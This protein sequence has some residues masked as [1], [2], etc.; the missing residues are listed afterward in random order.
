VID[1]QRAH[2]LSIAVMI[3][4]FVTGNALPLLFLLLA[5]GSLG[6]ELI[7]AMLGLVSV[8]AG[9]LRWWMTTYAVTA[10]TVEHRTGVFQRRNRSIRLD[11]IQQVTAVQALIPRAVGLA[12]VRVSEASADGDV[13]ISYLRLDAAE[14]LT[15]RLRSMVA[16][17]AQS[18]DP[19]ESPASSLPPPPSPPAVRLHDQ[20]FDLLLR[21][22]LAVV[23]PLVLVTTVALGVGV[24][25]TGL[26]PGPGAAGLVA[27]FG[28]ATIVGLGVLGVAPV[29]VRLGG[30]RLDRRGRTLR[31]AAGLMARRE[32]EVRTDRIQTLTV[33]SGPVARRWG[34][35]EVRFSAATGSAPAGESLGHLGPAV[36]ADRVAALVQGSVDLDPALGVE[37]EPVSP[38]TVRRALV[39]SGL[40]FVVPGSLVLALL[41]SVHPL[42]AAV[43]G[44]GWWAVAVWYARA[45]FAR[46][47][48]TVD[49]RRLVVR[50]GVLQHHL[51][52]LAVGNVQSVSVV[53]SFFQRRLVLADL[54]VAT[55]GVGSD[56]YVRIPDL[57]AA[58]AEELARRL[59]DAAAAT[60]WELRG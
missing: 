40:L 37:L 24:V 60:R 3:V 32:T 15:T 9:V 22:Q 7:G 52:Q 21:Y 46:L 1:W 56:H 33:G 45:R 53:A 36:A 49:D 29:L 11:R 17:T 55:A 51:T 43:T 38:L 14:D 25:A 34:L 39:R 12:A 5:G 18:T 42:A 8:G 57:P 30:F 16:V 58:R 20:Q 44:A 13:E 4:T 41:W 23:T 19:V 47:G 10:E 28:A 2:P 26:G 59:A 35:H 31:M 6:I 50:R 48:W 27:A 54:V